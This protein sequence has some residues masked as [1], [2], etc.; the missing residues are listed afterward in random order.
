MKHIL[1]NRIF[2]CGSFFASV[3]TYTA[4]QF[5]NLRASYFRHLEIIKSL[6]LSQPLKQQANETLVHM[7]LFGGFTV[8]A[9]HANTRTIATYGLGGCIATALHVRYKNGAR[10]A[11]MTHF[12]PT[13]ISE[14]KTA[15]KE[16]ISDATRKSDGNNGIQTAHFFVA[17]P[18]ALQKKDDTWEMVAAHRQK[19][20]IATLHAL[21]EQKLNGYTGTLITD[22][23]PYNIQ[24]VNDDSDYNSRDLTLTLGKDSSS[25]LLTKNGYDK[26]IN[27]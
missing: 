27:L 7:G 14:H 17:V 20:T 1:L 10:Y 22:V 16:L 4:D 13:D 2:L 26:N 9:N 18:G 5:N 6:Q 21:A 25:I 11:G 23:L 12:P 8:D 19:P 15:I 3:I 24:E